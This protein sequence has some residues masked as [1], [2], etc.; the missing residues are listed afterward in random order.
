MHWHSFDEEERH[1]FA[2]Y[3]VNSVTLV[4]VTTDDL[5]GA[6]RIFDVMNMRGLPPDTI[7]CVQGPGDVRTARRR[8]G[9]VRLPLG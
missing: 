6:H 8:G 3:L 7:G 2:S 1:R 5:D 9:H 4:I